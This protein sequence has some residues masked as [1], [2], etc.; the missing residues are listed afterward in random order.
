LNNE[1]K[2]LLTKVI[3]KEITLLQYHSHAM[4]IE[5]EKAGYQQ[6]PNQISF[7]SQEKLKLE[8]ELYGHSLLEIPYRA[9]N[10]AQKLNDLYAK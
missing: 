1:Q 7:H 10:V 2:E 9:S 6:D 8:E 5:A 4:Y 3:H